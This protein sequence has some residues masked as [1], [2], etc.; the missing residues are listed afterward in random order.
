MFEKITFKPAKGSMKNLSFFKNIQINR[1]PPKTP[2]FS[3]V[4]RPV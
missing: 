4:E 1:S 2:E 3:K